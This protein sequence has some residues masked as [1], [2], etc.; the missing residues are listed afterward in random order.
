MKVVLLAAGFGSRLW[1]L[2]TSG[3][4]KQFHTLLGDQSL[5]QYTYEL[6]SKIAEPQDIYVLTLQ[7]LEHWVYQQMPDIKPDK[8]LLVPER[9]NTYPH[10]LFVLKTI[11]T[12][13][14]EP[15]LFAGTDFYLSDPD[16]FIKT[17]RSAMH[18]RAAQK[19]SKD[20]LLVCSSAESVDANAGYLTVRNDRVTKFI[21]KPDADALAALAKKESLYKNIL[22]FITSLH[23]LGAFKSGDH[24]IALAAKKLID[25][26][27]QDVAAAFL[28]MP[29]CDISNTVFAHDKNLTATVTKSDFVDMGS[30]PALHEFNKKDKNGNVIF[31]KVI[32]D[33]DSSNNFIVNHTDQPLVVID[34]KDMAIVHTPWGNL[35]APLAEAKRVGDIYKK[36]IH[37]NEPEG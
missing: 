23:T 14:D 22:T 8:I 11:A 9:R 32:L 36:D 20:T 35:S 4:P 17:V 33:G 15:L 28:E 31:G 19:T 24:H 3:K 27:V 12:S 34:A 26:E 21:E 29:L 13:P 30:F 16:E 6:F 7:G 18:K 2:S 10:T 37:P 1:P 5:L 25:A